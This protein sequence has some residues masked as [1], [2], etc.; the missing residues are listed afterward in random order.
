MKCLLG[1]VAGLL[2]ATSAPVIAEDAIYEGTWLTTNRKLDGR[3]T[4][5]VS[6]L[7]SERWSGRFFGVWQGVP[8]DYTVPFSGPS[9]KLRGTAIIDGAQYEWTGA[10][11]DEAGGSFQGTFGGSRYL[12]AFELKAAAKTAAARPPRN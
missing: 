10:M 6:E 8:F 3:M 4:C 11:R 9:H 2:L 12:G 5:V 7:G 1:I